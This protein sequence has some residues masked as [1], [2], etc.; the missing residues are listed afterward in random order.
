MQTRI[1]LCHDKINLLLSR[2]SCVNWTTSESIK[3]ENSW[4][5][6]NNFTTISGWLV[7]SFLKMLKQPIQVA[8]I[9]LNE[10]KIFIADI[11]PKVNVSFECGGPFNG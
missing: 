1:L 9:S 4:E 3:N 2:N 8:A 11:L 10:I 5:N 7:F 6:P